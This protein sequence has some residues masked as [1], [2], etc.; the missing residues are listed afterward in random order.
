MG[1]TLLLRKGDLKLIKVRYR[2]FLKHWAGSQDAH[3]DDERVH[4]RVSDLGWVKRAAWPG[5]F[6]TS[7]RNTT[8]TEGYILR[9]ECRRRDGNGYASTSIPLDDCL[10]VVDGEL[11]WI[12]TDEKDTDGV[13]NLLTTKIQDLQL[14]PGYE[15]KLAVLSVKVANSKRKWVKTSVDLDERITN[16]DEELK[17]VPPA[18]ARRKQAPRN[19]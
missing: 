5:C 16:V 8:L 15:D 1:K 9:A 2:D 10:H 4:R 6:S 14:L 18:I 17:Y 19:L 13:Q 3:L 12:A 11:V 7:A